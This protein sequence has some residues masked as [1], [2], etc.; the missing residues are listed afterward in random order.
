MEVG[1]DVRLQ[2]VDGLFRGIVHVLNWRA[3][4]VILRDGRLLIIFTR[5]LV[6][7]PRNS[8]FM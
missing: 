6:V 5:E 8:C 3:E 1:A 4:F 2:T 7:K